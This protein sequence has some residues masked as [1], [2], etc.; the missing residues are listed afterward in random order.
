MT[1]DWS[2]STCTG[3]QGNCVEVANAA[4]AVMVRYTKDRVGRDDHHPDCGLARLHRHTEVSQ[5]SS[6][7]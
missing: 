6:R 1:I 4:P 2:M 3:E 7:D 5:P